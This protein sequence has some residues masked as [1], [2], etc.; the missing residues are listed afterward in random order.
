M[1]AS[2]SCQEKKEEKTYSTS[3]IRKK[4]SYWVTITGF[5]LFH[6]VNKI[7]YFF[8]LFFLIANFIYCHKKALINTDSEKK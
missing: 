2:L 1:L 5:F 8:D 7:A 6:V 3:K 4:A